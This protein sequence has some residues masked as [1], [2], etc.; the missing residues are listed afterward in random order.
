MKEFS[1][2]LPIAAAPQAVWPFLVDVQAWP[3][4]TSTMESVTPV[5]RDRSGQP[6]LAPLAVGS[7]YK[8]RQPQI[9]P[10]T[11]TVTELN[12]AGFHFA[13]TTKSFGVTLRAAHTLAPAR[14]GCTLTLTFAFN[15]LLA[16][17]FARVFG[18]ITQEYMETEA[19]GLKQRCEGPQPPAPSSGP[20]SNPA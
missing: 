6:D 16:P 13:W 2:T 17:I 20:V 7:Q 14:N 3:N 19:R 4:W 9:A 10:A 12:S 1:F 15:G 11:W 18:K 5:A 8:I